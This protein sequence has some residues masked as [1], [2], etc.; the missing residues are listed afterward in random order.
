TAQEF[1][2]GQVK[3]EWVP[4]PAAAQEEFLAG[5][6]VLS[7]PTKEI[8]QEPGKFYTAGAKES[9]YQYGSDVLGKKANDAATNALYQSYF[10][11]DATAAEVANWG[12]KGGADT[13]VRAL[14][15]FLK[16]ERTKYGYTEP[17]KPIGQVQTEYEA[18]LTPQQELQI[19]QDRIT[20]GTASDEDKKN[21][22]YA[23]SKGLL[24]PEPI[25]GVEDVTAAGGLEG[26]A[27]DTT[28]QDPL[29]GYE[30]GV[31]SIMAELETWKEEMKAIYEKQVN[32]SQAKADALTKEIEG[33]QQKRLD[34]LEDADPTKS[35][36]YDQQTRILQNQL[37][38][39]E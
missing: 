30:A 2:S 18:K 36:F 28:Y 3:D 16:K 4:D 24:P 20:A 39:A 37:D 31:N 7:K 15:D 13:T 25:E 14:E 38:V 26:G 19:A 32:D 21:V 34:I 17:I 27:P 10:G 22:D 29:P 11:R 12:E 1:E 8:T 35:Q 33:Y 23:R 9:G 5:G 6:G